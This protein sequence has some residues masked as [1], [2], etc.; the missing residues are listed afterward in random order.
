MSIEE[1]IYKNPWHSFT[2]FMTPKGFDNLNHN[3]GL[4]IQELPQVYIHVGGEGTLKNKIIRIGKAKKGA[5]DRWIKQ[6]WGHKNTFLWSIGGS[7]GYASYAKRYPNY[8]L[9]FAGLFELKTKLHVISCQS[10]DAMNRIEKYLIKTYCPIWEKYKQ[11]IKV[12]FSYNPEIKEIASKY[13]IAK[14]IITNQRNGNVSSLL[15]P[16]D[17]MYHSAVKQKEW[18]IN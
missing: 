10:I 1:E 2:L 11:E 15:N 3:F 16:L 17:V 9:F 8:L 5:I 14:E 18:F 7:R 13:G 12:Y 4:T 6:G